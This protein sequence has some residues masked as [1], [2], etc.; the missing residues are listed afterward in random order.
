MTDPDLRRGCGRWLRWGLCSQSSP[1]LWRW[2]LLR[3]SLQIWTVWL[4][5]G[6]H[7]GGPL[8][9]FSMQISWGVLADT[10]L[11]PEAQFCLSSTFSVTSSFSVANKLLPGHRSQLTFTR[12]SPASP[13][14]GSAPE[15]VPE[16]PI[17]VLNLF[18]FT[19]DLSAV[20]DS[21]ES[22]GRW[23]T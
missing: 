6:C 3:L 23:I 18:V 8:F 21:N 14:P 10:W 9:C 17:Q 15:C 12:C 20:R 5:L 11:L 16:K 2:G 4:V 22:V 13:K 7:V 1:V 19:Q